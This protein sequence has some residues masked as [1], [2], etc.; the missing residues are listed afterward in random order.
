MN[1]DSGKAKQNKN[2]CKGSKQGIGHTR[3]VDKNL[4]ENIVIFS[5]N[6]TIGLE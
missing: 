2:A 3:V 6:Y 4:R 1:C 5:R